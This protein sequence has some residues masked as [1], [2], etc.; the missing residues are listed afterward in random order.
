MI[1][2]MS[3]HFKSSW[4]QVF[5]LER[6]FSSI[7]GHHFLGILE[8]YQNVNST[9]WS[10][11][12]IKTAIII[13]HKEKKYVAEK[14]VP[15]YWICQYSKNKQNLRSSKG[16]R[17]HTRTVWFVSFE[18]FL[19]KPSFCLVLLIFLAR[20]KLITDIKNKPLNSATKHHT[21]FCLHQFLYL[22]FVIFF[23]RFH[24]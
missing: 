13:W 20:R 12:I 21:R 3:K 7:F 9:I 6:V 24:K 19:K 14:K 2:H 16:D 18:A 23:W 11:P 8:F 22:F 5:R 15:K 1:F 10:T 4:L 17:P